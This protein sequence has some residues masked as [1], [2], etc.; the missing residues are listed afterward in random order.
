MEGMFGAKRYATRGVADEVGLDIQIVLWS[1][2][3]KRKTTGKIDYLQVFELTVECQNGE[4]V[5]MIIHR[6]EVPPMKDEYII[7]GILE[8]LDTKIWVIDSGEYCTMLFPAEY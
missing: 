5:Q 7:R 1:L 8:P 3:G 6:Q 4:Q 2:I